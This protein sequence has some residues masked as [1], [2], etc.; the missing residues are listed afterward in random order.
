MY[1]NWRKLDIL[2]S[3]INS[4]TKFAFRQRNRETDTLITILRFVVG[5]GVINH[6]DLIVAALS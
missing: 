3:E 4:R 1:K 6:V 5:N 2:F